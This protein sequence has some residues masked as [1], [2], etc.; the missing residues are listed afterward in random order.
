M[1]M[2]S[3]RLRRK[4][5]RRSISCRRFFAVGV[6]GVLRAVALRR[7]FRDGDGHARPF[8]EPE[9]IEFI[10]HPLRAFG[11]DV[12]GAGLSWADGIVT[13]CNK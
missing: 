3:S 8:L 10:A 12:L 2:P 11:G 9:L 5:T 7:G 13:R 4:R 6:F 1:V